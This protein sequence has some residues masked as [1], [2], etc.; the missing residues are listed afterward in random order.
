M[1]PLHPIDAIS[2]AFE[3]T[4]QVILMPFKLGRAWKL[5]AC[6]YL[7]LL[8]G[9]FVPLPLALFF[10]PRGFVPPVHWGIL[11]GIVLVQ[12]SLLCA[13]FYCGNRMAFVE[14]EIMVTR[15]R[16]V[17][18]VW[19]R[20]GSRTW[21]YLGVKAAWGTLISFAFAPL[22]VAK[23]KTFIATFPQQA[24]PAQPGSPP[25]MAAFNQLVGAMLGF[26]ALFLIFGLVLKIFDSLLNDFVLPFYAIEDIPLS[27]AI[28]RG[29]DVIRREPLQVLL[30]FVMKFVLTLV[31][32]VCLQIVS[33]VCMIPLLILF[34]LITALGAL[35]VHLMPGDAG[36]L[37]I[38]AGGVLL[39][40]ALYLAFMGVII[41]CT[42]YLMSLLE[43]YAIYF[44]G[45]RYQKLGDYLQPPDYT[46]APPPLPPADD[47]E[48]GG[49]SLPMD[50]AL[51]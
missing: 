10:V 36:H 7:A 26:Y 5:A 34:F 25:D 24:A 4:R 40:G 11:L 47:E 8:G 38:V 42:G 49:P 14:F 9:I 32:Y 20:Y 21:P 45:G 29:W 6:S 3:R 12:F 27:A 28:A 37:L 46:Y 30:Y 43:A 1:Q 33:M 18:P 13:L 2:P 48:D 22:F 51:V 44:L 41:G 39:Y 16:F 15:A 50:P 23:F 19:R 35:A 31:G 17:A